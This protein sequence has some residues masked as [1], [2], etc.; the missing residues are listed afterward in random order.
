MR[1]AKD[2]A[3]LLLLTTSACACTEAAL[4]FRSAKAVATEAESQVRANGTDLRRVILSLGGTVSDIRKTAKDVSEASASERQYWQQSGA[5]ITGNL[6]KSNLALDSLNAL[7]AH[8]DAELNGKVLP[9]TEK[10][11]GSVGEMT[12]AVG[13]D[14]HMMALQSESTLEAAHDRIADPNLDKTAASLEKTAEHIE[15]ATANLQASTADIEQAVHRATRP[16]PFAEQVGEKILGFAA[17]AA[18]IFY[19]FVK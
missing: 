16:A 5:L 2:I 13:S 9:A 4:F 8:T 18:Q 14:L 11:V 15:Q 3:L 10:S 17:S 1:L 19:G 6:E 12:K 7:V